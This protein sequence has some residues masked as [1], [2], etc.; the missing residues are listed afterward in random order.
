MRRFLIVLGVV[1][2]VAGV[3]WPWLRKL[4]FGR[5]PGDIRYERDGFSFYFPLTTGLII[6]VVITLV[7]W[8]LRK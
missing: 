7:L 6:S 5:L 1:L 2:I 8:I 3:L 4:G